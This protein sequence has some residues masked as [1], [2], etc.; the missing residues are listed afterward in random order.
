MAKTWLTQEK[1]SIYIYIKFEKKYKSKALSHCLKL[2]MLHK[3]I[4]LLK[5]RF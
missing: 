3:S 4:I 5:F 2:I 1:G